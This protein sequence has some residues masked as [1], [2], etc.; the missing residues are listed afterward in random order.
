MNSSLTSIACSAREHADGLGLLA[1]RLFVAQE[2][3]QAGVMKLSAGLTAP[4]WFAGLDFPLM[5]TWLVSVTAMLRVSA[6]LLMTMLPLPATMFSLKVSTMLEPTATA[7]ALSAGLLEDRVGAVVSAAA[8]V[9][10]FK[11]VAL[12][13]PA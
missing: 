11:V 4:E 7:V 10:K 2:F 13:M 6:P 8:A 1:L 9:A 3:F 12:L 5:L